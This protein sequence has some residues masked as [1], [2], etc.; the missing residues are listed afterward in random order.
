M[1]QPTNLDEARKDALS[2]SLFVLAQEVQLGLSDN[3]MVYLRMRKLM[4]NPQFTRDLLVTTL[5]RND[6]TINTT[7]RFW[8]IDTYDIIVVQQN[9]PKEIQTLLELE[10]Q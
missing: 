3:T 7:V 1:N 10:A 5:E 2:N 4:T 6:D 8:L 9:K